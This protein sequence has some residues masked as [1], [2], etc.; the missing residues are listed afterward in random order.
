MFLLTQGE[1]KVGTSNIELGQISI[2]HTLAYAL[3]NSE[4]LHS[5]VAASFVKKLNM[6][7]E[8]LNGVCNIFL[9]L[10]ESMKL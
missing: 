8:L 4:A 10:G 2:A 9:V 1:T 6:V 3:T 7:T 5:F